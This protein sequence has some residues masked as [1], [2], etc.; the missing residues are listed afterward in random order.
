[1]ARVF[2]ESQESPNYNIQF[3]P[4]SFCFPAYFAQGK[5]VSHKVAFLK[6]LS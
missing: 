5:Q 3:I 4:R 1:M 6:E 2:S